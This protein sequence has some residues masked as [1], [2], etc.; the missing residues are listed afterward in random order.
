M[1]GGR[2]LLT[3]GIGGEGIAITRPRE[4]DGTRVA[5]SEGFEPPTF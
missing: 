2:T 4:W 3:T 5:R 1:T